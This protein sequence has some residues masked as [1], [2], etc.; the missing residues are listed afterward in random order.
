MA[1]AYK[2]NLVILNE[3]MY[4]FIFWPSNITS[5]NS[6]EDSK[7]YTLQT[8]NYEKQST[9]PYTEKLLDKQC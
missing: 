1:Q 9:Y 4:M 5:R 6:L 3:T 8:A 7:C 2:R